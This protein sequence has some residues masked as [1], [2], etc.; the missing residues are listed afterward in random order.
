MVLSWMLVNAPTMIVFR[1]ARSTQPYHM[2]T[3]GAQH[4]VHALPPGRCHRQAGNA[5]SVLLRY[6]L[7]WAVRVRA[8]TWGGARLVK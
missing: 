5:T 8:A 2:L 1:S 6:T 3:C 4:T 7:L